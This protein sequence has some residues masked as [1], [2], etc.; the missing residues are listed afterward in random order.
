MLLSLTALA[1]FSPIECDCHHIQA[2]AGLLRFT[3]LEQ[4][5]TR[6]FLR[7]V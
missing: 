2:S 1:D 5:W 7:S 3:R 6:R 4:T